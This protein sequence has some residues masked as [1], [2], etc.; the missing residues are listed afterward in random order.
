MARYFD[1]DE[2][3]KKLP[4]DL[5]YKASVKRVLMQAPAAD[6]VPREDL[7]KAIEN[8]IDA[9]DKVMREEKAEVAREIFNEIEK[10]MTLFLDE[11]SQALQIIT[12]VEFD[13]LKKKHIKN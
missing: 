11:K 9:Q 10:H 13:E 1:A 5:P 3:L 6:V 12:D 2:L 8:F 4:D 7:T